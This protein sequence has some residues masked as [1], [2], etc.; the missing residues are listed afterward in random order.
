MA[1]SSL[2]WQKCELLWGPTADD[3]FAWKLSI[4]ASAAF[5]WGFRALGWGGWSVRDLYTKAPFLSHCRKGMVIDA[6][7]KDMVRF[8][9]QQWTSQW[10]P[11]PD[12]RDCLATL[13]G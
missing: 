5:R 8:R 1:A 2:S 7:W 3:F 6:S 11:L 10:T 9:W 13:F 12:T 4:G